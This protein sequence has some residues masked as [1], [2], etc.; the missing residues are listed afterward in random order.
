[1]DISEKISLGSIPR[2]IGRVGVNNVLVLINVIT[3][4]GGE[5]DVLAALFAPP[6]VTPVY[7]NIVAQP[8]NVGSS[9]LISDRT[10]KHI[11]KILH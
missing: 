7:M 1:M 11:F 6:T 10:L 3:G 5:C 2:V 4:V 8:I 9:K